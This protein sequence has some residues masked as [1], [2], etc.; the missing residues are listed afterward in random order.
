MIINY[1]LLRKEEQIQTIQP[2]T[3]EHRVKT[4]LGAYGTSAL[5]VANAG[6][7]DYKT[8]LANMRAK[9]HPHLTII[10]QV[11]PPIQATI[12]QAQPSL[13]D[14][15]SRQYVS[16]KL[17]MSSY[18]KRN[19]LTTHPVRQYISNQTKYV[20]KGG[21]S[22]FIKG[23][24]A[25]IP[26][27]V[28]Q[29]C[30]KAGAEAFSLARHM[31]KDVKKVD[32]MFR[33]M[34]NL[35]DDFTL[36]PYAPQVEP[37]VT[38]PWLRLKQQQNYEVCYMPAQQGM[39]KVTTGSEVGVHSGV[40]WDVDWEWVRTCARSVMT[41]VL[42]VE[43]HRFNLQ[44]L[45][46]LTLKFIVRYDNFLPQSAPSMLYKVPATK[47][48]FKIP[49]QISNEL[50]AANKL[51]LEVFSTSTH[52]SSI[53]HDLQPLTKPIISTLPAKM[54]L[55]E[56]LS[57]LSDWFGPVSSYKFTEPLQLTA[58]SLTRQP[59]TI[60]A[61]VTQY[62]A[63]RCLRSP[64]LTETLFA[65]KAKSDYGEIIQCRKLIVDF[66]DKAELNGVLTLFMK[67][68]GN[69]LACI[70]DIWDL[71]T[72]GKSSGKTIRAIDANSLLQQY[73][74]CEFDI[75]SLTVF[76]ALRE[77]RRDLAAPNI[78]HL[79]KYMGL[80][81]NL[82]DEPDI[83]RKKIKRLITTFYIGNYRAKADAAK[84]KYLASSNKEEK[85]V[86]G[87]ELIFRQTILRL[88]AHCMSFER[89]YEWEANMVE[90][91][92]TL[93]IKYV[94]KRKRLQR[95]LVDLLAL[96]DKEKMQMSYE[97]FADLLDKALG[98]QFSIGIKAANKRI[99]ET[100]KDLDLLFMSRVDYNIYYGEHQKQTR[101]L[102]QIMNSATQQYLTHKPDFESFELE[103]DKK[104]TVRGLLMDDNNDFVPYQDLQFRGRIPKIMANRPAWMARTTYVQVKAAKRRSRDKNKKVKM[105]KK[106]LEV[107]NDPPE[108]YVSLEEARI[109]PKILQNI[110]TI[111]VEEPIV[112]ANAIDPDPPD[113]PPANSSF[114]MFADDDFDDLYQ[115]SFDK[116]M[117]NDYISIKFLP[118]TVK[119][120]FQVYCNTHPDVVPD[121][122]MP[123][124]LVEMEALE[125]DP[126][127]N[128]AVSALATLEFG[129]ST[130]T[131]P[132]LNV[133]IQDN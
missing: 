13:F 49:E 42:F 60:K 44:A 121:A 65:A 86:L 3:I 57:E 83:L 116:V 69:T 101:R 70:R 88:Y 23:S 45:D 16:A 63:Q 104:E 40:K 106:I 35:D 114:D 93:A 124:T 18:E 47:N 123:F 103:E 53:L 111:D 7:L 105:R 59:L 20:P 1:D 12:S 100:E 66:F 32:E 73:M 107:I 36:E 85:K 94:N 72:G 27:V 29:S 37:E 48:P 133:D 78:L 68:N 17:D 126:L 8:W 58:T 11:K 24:A 132:V 15:E 71:F 4:N 51:T 39:I 14:D 55:R 62:I 34:W 110:M 54:I 131:A 117:L 99:Q 97:R 125:A 108:E 119:A 128:S 50:N 64:K 84:S 127:F 52:L 75:L 19:D 22:P 38:K 81:L 115:T 90:S 98:T 10:D 120:F 43:G 76:E 79:M 77:L 56:G 46:G 102:R 30:I 21:S 96:V 109:H 80:R 61:L 25:P 9:S 74:S 6:Q 28:N 118:W 130:R 91:L 129:P 122:E 89:N 5:K 31:G 113:K 82:P 67:M 2:Q 41:R 26:A 92:K 112:V 33:W 95:K 87:K